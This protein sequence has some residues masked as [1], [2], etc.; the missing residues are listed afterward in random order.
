MIFVT[1]T[2]I[3]CYHRQAA[4]DSIQIHRQKFY[5]CTLKI[6]FYK[7][8]MSLKMILLLTCFQPFKNVKTII[9]SSLAIPKQGIRNQPE[10]VHGP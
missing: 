10:L 8:F 1:T 7:I 3:Y 2:K 9:I 4:I 6:E 5:F